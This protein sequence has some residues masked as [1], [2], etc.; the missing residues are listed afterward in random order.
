MVGRPCQI[1]SNAVSLRL[2]AEMIAAGASDQLVAN[3]IGGIR[4]MA[5]ARHRKP[6]RATGQ[7][8]C[9][10]GEQGARHAR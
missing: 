1:C 3:K 9:G 5:V 2:A 7:G 4:R 8:D 10:G 6:H